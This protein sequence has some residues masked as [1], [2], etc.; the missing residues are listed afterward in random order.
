M[1]VTIKTQEVCAQ[2]IFALG[3]LPEGA[4]DWCQGAAVG[5]KV[6]GSLKARQA[7]G[8]AHAVSVL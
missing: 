7:S 6:Y 4:H 8:S 2:T 1:L 5:Q 3:V